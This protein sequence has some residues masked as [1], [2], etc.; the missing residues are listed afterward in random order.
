MPVDWTIDHDAQQVEATA[1]WWRD[2]LTAAR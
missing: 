1:D 2:Q